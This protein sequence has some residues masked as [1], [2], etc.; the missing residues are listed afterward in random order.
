VPKIN[1]VV[2]D[3]INATLIDVKNASKIQLLSTVT[4]GINCFFIRSIH[5]K[6]NIFSV[7][8]VIMLHQHWELEPTVVNNVT[9]ILV[10][11]VLQKKRKKSKKEEIRQ[12][13]LKLRWKKMQNK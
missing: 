10:K 12:K 13:S 2:S 8:Y 7:I 9:L 1:V 3:A 6:S 11:T 4:K 5:K